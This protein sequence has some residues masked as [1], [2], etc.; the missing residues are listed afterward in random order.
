MALDVVLD[1]DTGVDDAL[2]LLFAVRCPRLRLLAVTCV[3]G[4]VDV[5][6][7][8]VNTLAV[9]ERAG[10][11]DVPVARGAQQ[12]LLEPPS[13]GRSVHGSDGL[14]DL[15]LPP[16][17]R[18]P[19]P[20]H[21]VA[22]LRDVLSAA[23]A[24]VTVLGLGPAT[25]LALLLRTYPAV[26]AGIGR[27]VLVAGPPAAEPPDFNAGHDPEALAVVLG[28]GVP[29]LT[30]GLDAIAAVTLAPGAVHPPGGGEDPAVSLARL[31]LRHQAR[32]Q[33]SGRARLGDA[34]ALA[35]VV[36]PDAAL[37]ERRSVRVGLCGEERGRL[38]ADPAGAPLDVVTSVAADALALRVAEVLD[39]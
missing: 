21:A 7:A 8:L 3:E 22:L 36:S 26:V 23:P 38:V 39:S 33:P 9:L 13:G 20:R 31:L 24:P 1:V 25:N 37:T 30:Y 10:A 19:D 17:A 11:A 5:D 34:G 2:A 29:V 28:S 12:P 16:P 6:R 4:N 18:T 15:A 14:A 32:R 35:L 27:L